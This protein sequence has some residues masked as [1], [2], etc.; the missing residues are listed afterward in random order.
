MVKR[1]IILVPG[2]RK[3]EQRAARDQLV[4]AI[5]DYS[6]GFEVRHA[7]DAAVAEE[8]EVTVL[9]AR[10]LADAREVELHVM[11]AYWNDLVPDWSNEAPLRRFWRATWLLFY[12][13]WPGGLLLSILKGKGISRLSACA[14]AGA[15]FLL[16]LWYLSVLI[17]LLE[18]FAN[19]NLT[20]SAEI[21][22]VLG[23][24]AEGFRAMAATSLSC[25]SSFAPYVILVMLIGLG[26]LNAFADFAAY[27]RAYLRDDP[28]KLGDSGLR[29]KTRSR[30]KDVLN[31][32][33]DPDAGF[34]EIFV[35]AHSLGGPVAMDALAEYGS[36]LRRTT[37]FTWGTGIGALSIQEP[38]VRAEIAKFYT[39]E[40]R[41]NSWIDIVFQHDLVAS[42][43]PVPKGQ[44]RAFPP[45]LRLSSPRGAIWNPADMHERYY[46]S[47][48]AIRPLLLPAP[49]PAFPPTE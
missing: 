28:T 23:S 29:A 33:S 42:I 12:W 30:V 43:V 38:I 35:V 4:G 32:V 41:L 31:E 47:E 11:E 13:L 15:G 44:K 49:P 45:P 39:S 34:D 36:A 48:D 24:H 10:D 20:N 19:S 8:S 9:T 17:V 46:R 40:T 26:K 1:A 2:Y 16:F 6:E 27:T 3:M 18:A 37:F 22:A 14:L 25:L 21:D 5:Q 7:G